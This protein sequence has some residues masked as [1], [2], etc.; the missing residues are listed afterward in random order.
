MADPEHLVS[1]YLRNV[2]RKEYTIYIVEPFAYTV[3]YSS[4]SAGI[5][6]ELR[7]FAPPEQVPSI[8][9]DNNNNNKEPISRR[10]P[11]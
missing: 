10:P 3:V 6:N 5:E 9:N 8:A 1:R 2:W 7:R 11:L 4:Q